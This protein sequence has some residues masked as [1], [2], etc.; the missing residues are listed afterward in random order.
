MKKQEMRLRKRQNQRMIE[1]N[2]R[3]YKY[4][5]AYFAVTTNTEPKADVSYPGEYVILSLTHTNSVAFDRQM[6][7]PKPDGGKPDGDKEKDKGALA[8]GDAPMHAGRQ[9]P[10]R[11]ADVQ[12]IRPITAVDGTIYPAMTST[13][14]MSDQTESILD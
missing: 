8:G 13:I 6:R 7:G 14:A 9:K 2:L 3:S 4:V 12:Q 11:S 1:T 10:V 5:Q